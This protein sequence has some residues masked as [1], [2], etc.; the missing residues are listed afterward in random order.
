MTVNGYLIVGNYGE[1][2]F[3]Q[4]SG[5]VT[6]PAVSVGFGGEG[7]FT[8]EG[9]EVKANYV[10][11]GVLAGSTGFYEMSGG[12]LTITQVEGRSPSLT[13]GRETGSQ[14]TFTQTGGSLTS[15]GIM[16]LGHEDGGQGTYDLVDGTL[17][18][19][20]IT[21]GLR[22]V[23]A[24]TQSGGTMTV[25]DTLAVKDENQAT[26]SGSFTQTG[27]ESIINNVKNWGSMTFD[28]CD[29][30]AMS[31]QITEMTNH[32]PGQV[33]VQATDPTDSFLNIDTMT[34]YGQVKVTSATL[35]FGSYTE[36]GSYTSDP[37]L[38]IILVDLDVKETGYL[39]GGPGDTWQIGNDFYNASAQNNLWDTGQATLVF[40]QSKG[41]DASH[42]LQVPGVDYGPS[43][44]GYSNNF[45][46]GVLDLLMEG[47]T[48]V[49]QDLILKDPNGGGG[50]L[51]VGAIEGLLFSG[52]YVTNIYG[53]G[54]NIYYDPALNPD[55]K[56]LTYVLTDGGLLA[57][58]VVPLPDS[59]WLL[60]T[61]LA[62][63]GL[64][65]RRRRARVE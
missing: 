10:E 53:N 55:L 11:V 33:T 5:T 9:G 7:T 49:Y 2:H 56:G 62:G 3:I 19:Q 30:A 38:T 35:T 57:P 24:F 40:F 41:Q 13:L 18:A 39:V 26:G 21:V 43:L 64:V 32:E 31:A 45:A 58:A 29:G 61:G 65:A 22:G 20:S 4:D 16:V 28:H 6:A 44:A 63:L 47:Q 50:A 17:E 59:V 42:I 60:L 52:E 34:N 46:W 1:G 54:L 37:A 51:Y 23:G 36:Y 27:G 8:Q 15:N 12:S 14:G 48:P 25:N